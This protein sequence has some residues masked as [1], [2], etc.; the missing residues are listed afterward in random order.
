MRKLTWLVMLCVPILLPAQQLP[1]K[2][3]WDRLNFFVGHWQG[4]TQGEPG[5]GK[6]G[7]DYQFVLKGR[8]LQEKNRT[9]YLPQ[10][11]NLKGE[12]HEDLGLYSYDSRRNKFVFRQFHG[13]GFVN[14]YVEQESA[15]DGKTLVFVTERIENIP[16]GWRARETWTI[17]NPD[18]YAEVFELAAPHQE[19]KVY[20]QSHWKRV[21]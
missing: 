20:S 8:F 17:V 10:E 6:G 4:T 18:E 11:R 13:E 2:T 12:V 5:H 14:E 7:R 1:A 21:K 9:V 19:F 15:A 3:S 16:E